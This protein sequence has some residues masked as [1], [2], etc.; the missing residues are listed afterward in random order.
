MNRCFLHQKM[1]RWVGLSILDIVELFIG[2]DGSRALYLRSVVAVVLLEEYYVLLKNC[3]VG[4]SLF[5][6][7]IIIGTCVQDYRFPEYLTFEKMRGRCEKFEFEKMTMKFQFFW[8]LNFTRNFKRKWPFFC[9]IVLFTTSYLQ[10][11]M[12]GLRQRLPPQFSRKELGGV[13]DKEV[14]IR[15]EPFTK[16]TFF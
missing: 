4:F 6:F 11:I 9:T 8:Y 10:N 15:Q 2:S 3:S 14:Y 16:M 5:S 7:I 13:A 1:I 12:E